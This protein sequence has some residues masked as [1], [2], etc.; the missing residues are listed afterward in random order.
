[1]DK[2]HCV[3]EGM[4]AGIRASWSWHILGQEP[5]KRE[6]GKRRGMGG[7]ERKGGKEGRRA[8]ERR[9]GRE[10][11]G[12]C[13]ALMSALQRQRISE[14]KASLKWKLLVSLVNRLYQRTFR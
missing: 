1:M 3:R 13:R 14:F 7:E 2:D 6:G 10:E 9:R 5:E 12:R 11:R 8:K 4:V